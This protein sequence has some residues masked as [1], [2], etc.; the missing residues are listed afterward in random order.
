[1]NTIMS[2]GDRITGRTGNGNLTWFIGHEDISADTHTR[3]EAYAA[4]QPKLEAILAA[5]NLFSDPNYPT[6]ITFGREW[7]DPEGDEYFVDRVYG[8]GHV[9]QEGYDLSDT[10][11]QELLEVLAAIM[12]DTD[13]EWRHEFTNTSYWTL[14]LNIARQAVRS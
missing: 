10:L 9:I 6:Q 11:A 13:V 1:M 14:N 5:T 8:H 2:D 7:T 4:A 3:D 12:A